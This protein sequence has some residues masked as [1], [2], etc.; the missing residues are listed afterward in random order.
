MS[1]AIARSSASRMVNP[2][3]SSF[4]AR[5]PAE[6]PG[7]LSSEDNIRRVSQRLVKL[8]IDRS[9]QQEEGM[10]SIWIAIRLVNIRALT[11]SFT[12]Q[13]AISSPDMIA[14]GVLNYATRIKLQGEHSL[15]GFS[16]LGS[17]QETHP[18]HR[19][20]TAWH[21]WCFSRRN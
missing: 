5:T 13:R 21:R 17:R 15:T 8:L 14:F 10:R 1:V 9:K 19:Q 18:A 11:S 7:L 16:I 3:H 6:S 4:N 12:I 2:N 20:A